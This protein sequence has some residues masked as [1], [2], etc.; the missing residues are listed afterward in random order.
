MPWS[1]AC[2]QNVENCARYARVTKLLMATLA[3]L[4]LEMDVPGAR[5][6]IQLDIMLGSVANRASFAAAVRVFDLED[7]DNDIDDDDDAD[8]DDAD[9]FSRPFPWLMPMQR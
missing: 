5:P 1:I 7:D 6:P 4:K 2:A 3:G 8:D 9:V